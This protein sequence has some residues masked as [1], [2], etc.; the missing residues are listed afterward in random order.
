[1]DVSKVRRKAAGAIVAVALLLV[2]PCFARAEDTQDTLAKVGDR[3][4]TGGVLQ[5]VA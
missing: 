3:T 2:V 4:I 5:V 1:M